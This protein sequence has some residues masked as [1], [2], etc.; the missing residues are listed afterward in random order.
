[1]GDRVHVKGT[2]TGE[3]FAAKLVIVQTT[4]EKV[5]VNAKGKITRTVPQQPVAGACA[6]EFVVAGW[7]VVYNGST[8]FRKGSCSSLVVNAGV[9]VKGDVQPAGAP[10]AGKVLATWIQFDK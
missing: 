1:V 3:T 9:H 10:G 7:T 5:P 6:T 4:N 8:D 2:K